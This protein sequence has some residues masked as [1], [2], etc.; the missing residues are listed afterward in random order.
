MSRGRRRRA[1]QADLW[2]LLGL[3]LATAVIGVGAWAMVALQPIARDT[4]TLCATA[5]PP[6]HHTLV[7]VD[8]TDRFAPGTGRR[9]RA[10]IEAEAGRMAAGDRLTLM[11]MDARTPDAPRVLFSKCEPGV[12]Q[13]MTALW[14]N[15]ERLAARRETDFTQPLERATANALRPRSARESPLIQSIA[16]AALDPAFASGRHRRLVV[17]SD[18]LQHQP[19]VFTQYE[20]GDA[21]ARFERSPLGA[22][23]APDLSTL[24]VRLALVR[25]DGSE[26]YQTEGLE[27]FWL[28]WFAR[29]GCEARFTEAAV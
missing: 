28:R 18:F 27:A 16:A 12:A 26:A 4:A 23:P 8:A 6:E 13:G 22:R 19:G 29:A 11:A 15:P 2:G 24:D 5:I 17:V 10:L 1:R 3:V 14:S 21:W 25:R 7:L 20:S 9:I